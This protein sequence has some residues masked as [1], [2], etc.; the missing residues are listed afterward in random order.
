MT[1]PRAMLSFDFGAG[2]FQVRAAAIIRREGHI[3]IHRM[4]LDQFWT[5]PGGRVEFGEPAATTVVREIAEELGCAAKVV[6]LSYF[7]E[8]MFELDQH[9]VHEIGLYFEA[10]IDPSF[11]FSKSEI[12]H[13]AV[14]GGAELEFRWVRTDAATLAGYDLKPSLL[15]PLLVEPAHALK[16]MVHRG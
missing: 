9:E 4:I 8:N 12:C 1:P 6:G 13:R 10:D 14:D 3:L 11:P 16:H 5:L 15:I 7:V 2:K